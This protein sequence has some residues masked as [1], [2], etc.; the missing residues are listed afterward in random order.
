MPLSRRR[1]IMPAEE[2]GKTWQAVDA[3]RNVAA[4]R[5]ASDTLSGSG[6]GGG[7]SGSD[8]DSDVGDKGARWAVAADDSSD[9][10]R[11]GDYL[12]GALGRAAPAPPPLRH[13]I[14]RTPR[15]THVSGSA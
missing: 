1:V 4:E 9:D 14:L 5:A 10:D 2:E 6:E 8:A 3:R 15:C 12:T 13:H 11:E 7:G